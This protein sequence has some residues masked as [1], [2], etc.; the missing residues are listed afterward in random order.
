MK[1]NIEYVQ[2]K[3][4]Y[5]D[6]ALNIVMHAYEKERNAVPCLPESDFHDYLK[7]SI[8]YLFDNGS[9][10]AAINGNRLIGF[11]SGY[12]VGNFFGKY[13]GVYCPVFGHGA[14][15]E[16]S[17]QIYRDIYKNAAQLWVKNSYLTH[18][19]TVFAHDQELV[20]A[21]FW[22]GFGLR[23]IDAIRET[24]KISVKEASIKIKKSSIEDAEEL[25]DI[26]TQHNL[27]YR[28]SPIFMPKESA[29][30]VK[31][32]CSWLSKENHHE[33]IAYRNNIPVGVMGIAP[34]AETFVSDHPSVMNIKAAYVA[35]NERSTGIG[36]ILLNTV[37]EW[38]L[39][40]GYPLCGVDFESINPLGS[41][42]W[43]KYF[44]PY[45]YSLVRRIDERVL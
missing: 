3:N 5:V 43:I 31:E 28:E 4:I 7:N 11:L 19:I 15:G 9:G 20:N 39:Q 40:N 1:I 45:T 33:W 22:Q 38:L 13:S 17:M 16:N 25:A 18:A 10:I 26:H 44:S 8:Q 41:S 23:C 29:D 36:A 34:S 14:I 35:E 21:W 24:S 32:Y 37:Q 42:F 30:A 12:V 27:Y 2:I 6:E